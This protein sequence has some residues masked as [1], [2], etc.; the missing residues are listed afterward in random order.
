MLVSEIMNSDTINVTP[1][2]TVALASRL[3]SRHNI[4]SLPVCDRDGTLRGMITDRDI[5]L[6]CVATGEDP[7]RTKV[8]EIMSRSIITVSP[9]DDVKKAA[10]LMSRGQVRR[11]PVAEDGVLTGIVTLCDM[12]QICSLNME[13]AHALTEI[14]L[15]IR[16]R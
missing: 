9:S 16:Q 15:N 4:G 6:R 12:A 3:L 1:E 11:L 5:V 2:E 14:S 10:E 7:E 8:R 13:A